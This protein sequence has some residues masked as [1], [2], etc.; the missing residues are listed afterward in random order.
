M[1]VVDAT[2]V[3][4][5]R[6]PSGAGSACV[7]ILSSLPAWFSD[8]GA[9]RAYAAAAERGPAILAEAHGAPV[10]LALLS[11]H[12]PEAAEMALFAVRPEWHRRGVG[13]RL[14]QLA[15]QVLAEDGVRYLQV[16]TLS[17]RHRD[18]G[19][20]ATRAFYRACGFVV[21]EELPTLWGPDNP[22]VQ[23]VKSL[24]GRHTGRSPGDV[25]HI[26]LWVADLSPAIER[27]AWL[28]GELGYEAFQDWPAGRSWRRNG[29]YVVLEQSVALHGTEHDRCRPG[30]NH[31]AFHA[32]TR[33]ALDRLVAD[34]PAHGWQQLFAEQY[35][36]AGG[37]D[38]EAAY[39]VDEDG[40]EVELVV[41][42]DR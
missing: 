39:L 23:L 20:A 38:H 28:L 2:A 37:P 32:G 30:L 7:E 17:A 15:E 36:H 19:Y 11:R 26:E 6:A 4:L 33:A 14:L 21:L 35:P 5:R 9:N 31:L 18:A 34:A 41:D 13:R 8:P 22:A 42:R 12:S 3:E 16:K 25:H 29:H 10:G 24:P 1:V 40:F 27:W